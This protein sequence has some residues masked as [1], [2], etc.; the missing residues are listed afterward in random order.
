MTLAS[1]AHPTHDTAGLPPASTG[2]LA[3][4]PANAVTLRHVSKQFSSEGPVILDDV[5]LDVRPGEFV[6][7]VGA[8]GCGK[9]TLLNLITGLDKPTSGTIECSGPS[10]LMFQE[11]ALMPWLTAGKN[12][13]LAMLFNGVGRHAAAR[14]DRARPRARA[15]DPA[16][17]RAVRRA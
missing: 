14:G 5:S 7:L 17:G 11:P 10:S 9:S 4:P 3:D 1:G 6:S 12:V 15:L 2:L 8:S 16:H 13:E